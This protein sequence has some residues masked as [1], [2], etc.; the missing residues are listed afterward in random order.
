MTLALLYGQFLYFPDDK[1][2]YIP[3]V[4]Q[5]ILLLLLVTFIFRWFILKSKKDAEA[6]KEL[7]QRLLQER[8][9]QN[10]K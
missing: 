4:M 7:E 9:K 10:Q 5:L 1:T 6:A 3:A 2:T 8:Q